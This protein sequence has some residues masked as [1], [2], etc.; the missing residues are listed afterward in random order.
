MCLILYANE[1][2]T[3]SI[4]MFANVNGS[5][6]SLCV[7]AVAANAAAAVAV[8]TCNVTGLHWLYV[9]QFVASRSFRSL[10][11]RLSRPFPRCRSDGGRGRRQ[12]WTFHYKL[13]ILVNNETLMRF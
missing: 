2:A 6:P 1:S 10:S 5:I 3:Q 4:G 7:T 8:W 12:R 11:L 13:Y 9:Y